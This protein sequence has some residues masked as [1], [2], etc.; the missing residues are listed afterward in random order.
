MVCCVLDSSLLPSSP[1]TPS[2]STSVSIA[3]SS[4][5]KRTP[6]ERK[7]NK[8][9]ERGETPLHLVAIKGDSKQAQDLIKA[10]ADVNIKD[11]AGTFDKGKS[12]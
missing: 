5:T 12:L 7:A 2:T 10:G 3:Y 1:H 8:R 4:S 9:N 6:L 11:F